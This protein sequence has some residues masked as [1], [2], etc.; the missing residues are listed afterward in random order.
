MPANDSRVGVAEHRHDQAL[1][2]AD[3]DADVV[4]VLEDHLVALDLGVQAREGLQRADARLDE[5]RRDAE[6]DA[7]RFLNASLRRSRSAISA[8]HVHLVEGGEHGRRALRLDEVARDRQAPLRHAHALSARVPGVRGGA[9]GE[10]RRRGGAWPRAAGSRRG[11]WRRGAA[12]RRR[13]R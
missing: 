3:G 2:R 13:R 1:R 10:R 9:G 5:E 11:R 7:V 6:A 8:R 12:R 4:V